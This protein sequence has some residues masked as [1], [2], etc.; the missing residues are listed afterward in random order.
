MCVVG[1]GKRDFCSQFPVRSMSRE[2]H[3]GKM[4]VL[5]TPSD[6]RHNCGND[7]VCGSV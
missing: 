7:K 4:R 2:C 5:G 1:Q 3:G 6:V